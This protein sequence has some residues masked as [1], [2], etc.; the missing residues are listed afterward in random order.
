MDCIKWWEK[1]QY[2][3]LASKINFQNYS[4]KKSTSEVQQNSTAEF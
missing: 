3:Y 1:N 4:L 2:F